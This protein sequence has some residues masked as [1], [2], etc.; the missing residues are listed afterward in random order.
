MTIAVNITAAEHACHKVVIVD[1]DAQAS[2]SNL[3]D[4]VK[5]TTPKRL[6]LK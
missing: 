1:L 4:W 2:A 5:G 6:P 3:G